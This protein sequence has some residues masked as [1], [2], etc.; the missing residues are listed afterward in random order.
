MTAAKAA[1]TLTGNKKI[2]VIATA[3]TAAASAVAYGVYYYFFRK[4][5]KAHKPKEAKTW[6]GLSKDLYATL[7]AK[8][9]AKL[10]RAGLELAEPGQETPANLQ[11]LVAKAIPADKLGNLTAKGVAFAEAGTKLLGAQ[12]V[13]DLNKNKIAVRSTKASSQGSTQVPLATVAKIIGKDV[14]AKAEGHLQFVQAG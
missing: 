2:A 4:E 7:G 5:K 14:L 6:E 9:M 3:A 13:A 1:F 10:Y 8:G 12:A 11:P